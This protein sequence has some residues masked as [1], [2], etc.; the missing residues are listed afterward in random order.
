MKK[1]YVT[2]EQ[3]V[4]I[5]CMAKQITKEPAVKF[6]QIDAEA[7]LDQI[8]TKFPNVADAL[9]QALSETEIRTTH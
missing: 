2:D 6:E 3:A 7:L 8:I 1:I 9:E 4:M 5:A